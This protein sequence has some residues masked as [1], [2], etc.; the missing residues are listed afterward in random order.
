MSKSFTIKQAVEYMHTNYGQP[1]HSVKSIVLA[2]RK[3]A[4][5]TGHS[6]E[7]LFHLMIENKDFGCNTHSYGFN[8]AYGRELRDTLGYYYYKS[9]HN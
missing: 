8:T 1:R 5:E 6:A 3:L 2:C 4:K 7:D 9:L